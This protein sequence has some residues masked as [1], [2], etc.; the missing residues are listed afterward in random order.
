[1]TGKWGWIARAGVIAVL[2]AFLISSAFIVQLDYRNAWD[3]QQT[4]WQ[5]LLPVI[6]DVGN[7]EVVLV[8]P[9]GLIDSWQIEAN[10]WNMPRMLPQLFH[11]PEGDRAHPRA[12][13]LLEGWEAEVG[14]LIVLDD[15]TTQAPPSLYTT[16]D[17]E[18]VIFIETSS[19]LLIRSSEWILEDGMVLTFKIPSPD[20]RQA[21]PTTK[22][23]DFLIEED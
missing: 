4:F 15:R 2:L 18:D 3:Y 11:F 21:Y 19:G 16:V 12:Y 5:A 23:Y 14:N 22:L 9:K 10:T 6:E 1:M 17:P 7:G 8:E 13:R 20:H